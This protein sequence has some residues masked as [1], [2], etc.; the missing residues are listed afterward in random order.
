MKVSYPRVLRKERTR[1]PSATRSF[2]LDKAI[3]VLGAVNYDFVSQGRASHLRAA[4]EPSQTPTTVSVSVGLTF[5]QA[6]DVLGRFVA[7]GWG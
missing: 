4:V 1:L 2:T 7:S 6:G 5:A 3:G